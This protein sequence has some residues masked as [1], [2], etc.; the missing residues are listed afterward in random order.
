[1]KGLQTEIKGHEPV[2]EAVEAKG[3]SIADDGACPCA[4]RIYARCDE[5]Q[6][7]W[8]KYEAL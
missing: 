3:K 6:D 2:I 7:K 4:D 8:K 5:L 1:L